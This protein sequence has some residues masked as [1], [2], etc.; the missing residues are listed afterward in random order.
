M[1]CSPGIDLRRLAANQRG[2]R[3]LL[4]AL[5][6]PG[7]RQNGFSRRSRQ[8]PSYRSS[9]LTDRWAAHPFFCAARPAYA[10]HGTFG[11]KIHFIYNYEEEICNQLNLNKK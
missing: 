4:S 8:L 3:Q 11:T 6:T 2:T 10:L 5:L 9:L 7:Q 1:Q